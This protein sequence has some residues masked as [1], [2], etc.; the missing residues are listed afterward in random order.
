MGGPSTN[1]NPTTPSKTP[2]KQAT[3]A[4]SS[5]RGSRRPWRLGPRAEPAE[6]AARIGAAVAGCPPVRPKGVSRP[7]G[8]RHAGSSIPVR[9]LRPT[10]EGE[11][12]LLDLRRCQ[13]GHPPPAPGHP[14][15]HDALCLLDVEAVEV[16]P[17]L[18]AAG[19][20]KREGVNE[21][22][23]AF[24]ALSIAAEDERTHLWK[25]VQRAP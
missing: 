12:V 14:P 25:A 7:I 22:T 11:G 6:P 23:H 18:A 8:W 3:R 1:H 9:L 2:P 15:R 10:N 13:K 19:S 21:T 20:L 4:S 5:E 17:A 16:L 24:A